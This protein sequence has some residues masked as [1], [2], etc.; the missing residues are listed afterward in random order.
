MTEALPAAI[1][2]V[3]ANYFAPLDLT[4]VFARPGRLEVDLGCGDGSFL[5]AM[6]QKFPERN[7]LGIERLFGRVRSACDRASRQA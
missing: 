7:Y 5:V 6:A 2:L 4:T 1:E 3:P